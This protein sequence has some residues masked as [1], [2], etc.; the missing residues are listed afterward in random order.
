[1]DL[2]ITSEVCVLHFCAV[3]SLC[4]IDRQPMARW[5]LLRLVI[6]WKL[7][8]FAAWGAP[9]MLYTLI[10]VPVSYLSL[11]SFIIYVILFC[12]ISNIIIIWGTGIRGLMRGMVTLPQGNQA[13][14]VVRQ[15]WK[16]PGELGVSKS[17]ECDTF[18]F[19]AL[20]LLVGRQEG[21]PA[22]KKLVLVCWWWWFDW[23]FAWLIAPLTTSIILWFNKHWLTQV[24]L[25]NG[26]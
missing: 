21:H 2:P 9:K 23:S 20:T 11:L 10:T 8:K 12:I 3:C 14:L 13:L 22:C 15:S 19:S 6:H 7:M 5:F 18:P 25:E 4:D 1:M 17:M 16:T 26:R 24:H